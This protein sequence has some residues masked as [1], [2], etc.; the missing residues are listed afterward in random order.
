MK[1]NYLLPFLCAYCLLTTDVLAQP[2]LR[3]EQLKTDLAQFLQI[4]QADGH[5]HQDER[6]FRLTTVDK[7][8]LAEGRADLYLSIPKENLERDFDEHSLEHYFLPIE[9]LLLG[10][11]IE[12]IAFFAKNDSG[13]YDDMSK[14]VQLEHGGVPRYEKPTNTDPAPDIAGAAPASQR[15]F[16][17]IGQAQPQG[18][19]SG[20]TVWLSPGHGWIYYSSLGDYSTQR[21]TSNS[22]VEDFGT[23]EIVSYY[24]MRYLWN[25]GAKVWLVRE[26][27][28]NTHEVIVNNDDGAPA[29]TE[30]GGWST[31]ASAGYNGGT[32]KYVFSEANETA[33]ATFMPTIPQAG[34]YW[35][36]VYYREGTNRPVDTRYYV[37]HAGG[38]TLVSVNQEVHGQTWLYLGQ[39]YFDQGTMG[40]VVLSNASSDVGQ[41]VIADAVRFGGGMGTEEECSASNPGTSGKPRFE[42]GALLYAPYMNYPNCDGDV[43]IR[44]LYAEWELSK[45]TAAE[46]N[47]INTGDINSI[48]VSWHTNAAGDASAKGTSTFVY[49]P[50]PGSGTNITSDNTNTCDPSTLGQHN[51]RLRNFI[52][53]EVINDIKADWD[54]TWT[55]RGRYCANFGELRN[56]STM[57]GCLLEM[58]F[59]TSPSDATAI[60]TPEFR[61]IEARATY[62]GIVNF[63]NYYD[64]TIS[65]NF[66]PEPPTHL[67]AVNSGPGEIT[68]TWAAPSNGGAGGAAATGY[69]LYVGTHGK[70]FANGIAVSGNAYTLTGLL[71]STVY[72]FKVSATNAGGESFPTATVSAKTPSS[73]APTVP[74]LIVDGFDR[75]E[76]SQMIQQYENA[77]LGTVY[78]G[79][80]ERMNTYD[81]MVQH[82][83]SLATCAEYGFDGLSNEAVIAGTV[84]LNDYML[85]DWITGEESTNDNTLNATER[86]LVKNYLDAGG[87]LIISGAEIG[88]DIG[89]SASAN[90]DLAFYNNYLKSTYVGDDGGTYN[91]TGLAGQIFNGLTGSFD[92]SSLYYDVNFP[93][94]LGATGGSSVVLNYSGGTADGAA[95][96]YNNPS[97]FGVV[98]YGF[99]L[100]TVTN[101]SVRDQLLCNALAY[102]ADSLLASCVDTSTVIGT[103]IVPA[104]YRASNQ[105]SSYGQIAAGSTVTFEADSLIILTN[106]FHAEANSTFTA[107]IGTCNGVPSSLVN[108]LPNSAD[109]VVAYAK[110]VV[111][112]AAPSQSMAEQLSI[113]PNPAMGQVHVRYFLPAKQ[114]QAPAME[115]T[116]AQGR[117]VRRLPILSGTG[118]QEIVLNVEGLSPGLYFLRLRSD[119]SVQVRKLVVMG[120][121]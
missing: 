55:D 114:A 62:Q 10:R 66:I 40:K 47:D 68:L 65:T 63:F 17:Q 106:G 43:S 7:V 60:T 80:L 29:Y 23:T 104:T 89:R 11:G 97:G 48:F 95:V 12:K 102:I 27:D 44:P 109:E 75:L 105:L 92:N 34:W 19:L 52:H 101:E 83:Q 30:T 58:G 20:K 36:S 64:N 49:N 61:M 33:T 121:R 42:E 82:A 9:N 24:L 118:W 35:V 94:R 116:N 103:P 96:A 74:V 79:F 22:M 100:E 85:V 98:N 120:R 18:A 71:P 14:Y 107:R 15:N 108:P 21:G 41:A 3:A 25:A 91:F 38:T 16:P 93:D 4:V 37:H 46:Q 5:G 32:Y 39:F 87:N 119:S 86:T 81:Y 53:T 8:A 84:S 77:S 59:H 90:A 50:N 70:G 28:Y 57:P 112:D 115:L 26:R 56:L 72:Y 78:R 6:L 111:D 1:P 117:Q 88:W 110:S 2:L 54:A 73:H 13:G 31:S 45:G 67:A 99:G 69:T 76:R 51:S 113:S